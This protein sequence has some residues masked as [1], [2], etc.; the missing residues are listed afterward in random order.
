M[1][2]LLSALAALTAMAAVAGPAAAAAPA[3]NNHARE[4][5]SRPAH[6]MHVSRHSG[7]G[8]VTR[9]DSK[10]N[11]LTVDKRSYAY[12]PRHLSKNI[13]QGSRITFRWRLEN[14]H[15]TAYRIEPAH[16]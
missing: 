1:K 11:A 4:H 15:R 2:P 8:I 14:G 6:H 3:K 10:R 16:G 5:A 9:L 12:N 7:S 13:T